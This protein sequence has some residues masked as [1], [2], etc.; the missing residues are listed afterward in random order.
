LV[1]PGNPKHI[2][3]VKTLLGPGHRILVVNGAGHQGL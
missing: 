1:R 3:G 2:G